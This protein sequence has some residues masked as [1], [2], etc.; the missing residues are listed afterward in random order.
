MDYDARKDSLLSEQQSEKVEIYFSIR[1]L[2]ANSVYLEVY[3]Q[4]TNRPRKKIM[5][6]KTEK[7]YNSVID[8]PQSAVLEY[9]FEGKTVISQFVKNSQFKSMLPQAQVNNFQ[10]LLKQQL[11]KYSTAEQ[12]ESERIYSFKAPTLD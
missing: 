9:F 3:L 5:Q 7:P 12:K 6:T 4:E 11:E 2:S 1:N 10:E 8:F